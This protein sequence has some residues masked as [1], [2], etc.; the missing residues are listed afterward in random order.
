M[1]WGYT[2][3]YLGTEKVFVHVMDQHGYKGDEDPQIFHD[4][5]PCLITPDTRLRGY[6]S[7]F[8]TLSTTSTTTTI[9]LYFSDLDREQLISYHGYPH[10]GRQ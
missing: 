1:C 9:Y 10:V 5:V 2:V 3:Q 6:L 8:S 7:H 4:A